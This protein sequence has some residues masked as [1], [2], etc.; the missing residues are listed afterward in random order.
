[1]ERRVERAIGYCDLACYKESNMK[2]QRLLQLNGAML[3]GLLAIGCAHADARAA[4][5]H[6]DANHHA[7]CYRDTHTDANCHAHTD[8]YP[9][10]YCHGYADAYPA[11]FNADPI[12]W[13]STRILG[14]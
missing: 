5:R 3:L 2:Y 12:A 8:K 4:H 14:R 6:A 13:P 11:N 1:M 7:H 9:N 10:A